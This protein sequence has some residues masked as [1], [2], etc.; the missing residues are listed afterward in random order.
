MQPISFVFVS[1]LMV[2]SVR[3]LIQTLN[4]A[5][6]L[7]PGSSKVSSSSGS[8]SSS[9]S[10]SSGGGRGSGG[11][12]GG[13]AVAAG[14]GGSSEELE[15]TTVALFVTEVT[16]AYFVATLL[17]LRMSVPAEYRAAIARGVGAVPVDFFHRLFDMV[18]LLA[19]CL[20]TVAI[21]FH[22]VSHINRV[23]NAMRETRDVRSAAAAAAAGSSSGSGGAGW[24]GSAV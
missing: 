8:N 18:F 6:S 23:D 3:G 10:S 2:S 17:L 20:G 15:A 7:A 9:S 21:I 11:G 24:H 1:I 4:R 12:G 5:L 14:E 19:F 16:G 13:A 22:V